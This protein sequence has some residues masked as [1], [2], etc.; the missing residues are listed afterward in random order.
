MKTETLIAEL[1]GWKE[2]DGM[3]DDARRQIWLMARA[4]DQLAGVNWQPIETAPHNVLVLLYSPPNVTALEGVIEV[5]YAS[6][7]WR[8]GDVSNMSHHGNATYWMAL[9]PPPSDDFLRGLKIGF[10]QAKNEAAS[11]AE[12]CCNTCADNIRAMAHKGL[13]NG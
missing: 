3:S 1:R 13:E 2:T 12:T 5:G 11:I 8:R 4:A 7:G 9:P 10:D 6:H